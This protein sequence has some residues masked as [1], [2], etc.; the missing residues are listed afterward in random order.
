MSQIIEEQELKDRAKTIVDRI[1]SVDNKMFLAKPIMP[2]EPKEPKKPYISR[3]TKPKFFNL[4]EFL[5]T[6]F[7]I[8]IFLYFPLA[9]I[10]PESFFIATL[11][12]ASAISLISLGYQYSN[13]LERY[14]ESKKQN[15][16][17]QREYNNTFK[18]YRS[19]YLEYQRLLDNYNE[20]VDQYN[21]ELENHK[22]SR[23][24]LESYKKEL[25]K[26]IQIKPGDPDKIKYT[27]AILGLKY[28]DYLPIQSIS[29]HSTAT[30]TY[31]EAPKAKDDYINKAIKYLAGLN[32]GKKTGI[33][34]ALEEVQK[35]QNSNYSTAEKSQR[36]KRTLWTNQSPNSKLL[37][38]G[39]LGAVFGL[40]VFGTGG[41]GIAALG[42]AMGIWGWFA[43]A[44]GGVFISSLIQN[45]EKS[46]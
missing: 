45:F 35:I 44:A 22:Y 41:I 2:K 31:Y 23:I 27:K 42:G 6:V 28:E 43:T 13:A 26:L 9:W 16:T 12:I 33:L 15:E 19:D 25:I 18:K 14:N 29:T 3:L 32:F 36:I 1:R 34:N 39:L 30:S 4:P 24:A 11:L 8:S 40:T 37:I 21:Q 5:I 10:I 46:K 20:K 7:F 38:G 17:R